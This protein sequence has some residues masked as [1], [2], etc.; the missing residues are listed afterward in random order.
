MDGI[1]D[2]PM[3]QIQISIVKPDVLFTEFI[4]VEGFLR[5]PKAFD[6]KVSFQKNEKPIVAQ[7]YGRV[8]EDFYHAVKKIS[9]LGFSGIDIN[10]GCPAR[11]VVDRKSGGGLIGNYKLAEEIIKNSLKAIKDSGK[12]LPLSVKTRIGVKE[13]IVGEW[14]G[15]LSQFPLSLVTIH[16]RLLKNQ[17]SGPVDWQEIGKAGEILKKKKIYCLGNGGVESITQAE[18]YSTRYGLDGVLIGRGAWGNPWA[19]KRN[20]RPS[21]EEILKVVQAHSD[22]VAEFYDPEGF[23]TVRKHFA[24]YVK[25]FSG[26]KALKIKL[27]E[28]ESNQEVGKILSGFINT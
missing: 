23:V 24:R 5:N 26:A 13:P 8:P 3:R 22:K 18:K 15:F 17:H 19:F 6:R 7:V 14:I 4:N 25:G 11:K 12:S 9:R 21:V 28:T 27:L 20:Y 2:L 10:M 1:T 16:G